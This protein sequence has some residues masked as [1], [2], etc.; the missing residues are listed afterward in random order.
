VQF[1]ARLSGLR[2]YSGIEVA[3]LPKLDHALF[4]RTAREIA[5]TDAQNW[6]LTELIHPAPRAAEEVVFPEAKV[7]QVQ[8][9]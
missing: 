2:R 5:M 6:L 1:G 4:T 8:V 7:L 9:R 3:T